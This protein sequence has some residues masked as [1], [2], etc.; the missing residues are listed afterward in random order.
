MQAKEFLKKIGD[1]RFGGLANQLIRAE[2]VHLISG[3]AQV[4]VGRH[5]IGIDLQRWMII[6]GEMVP[7]VDLQ[8]D[9]LASGQKQQEVHALTR[10]RQT[11]TQGFHDSGV[12]VEIDLG[13]Q[14]GERL[15]QERS[16]GLEVD[17]EEFALGV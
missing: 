8:H 5:H 15:S 6:L 13:Q 7:P 14:R 10:K 1:P 2:A 11:M 4:S 16:I 9:A 3:E 17:C 12:V